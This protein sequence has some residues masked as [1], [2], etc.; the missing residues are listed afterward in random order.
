MSAC[1]CTLAGT[2]ACMACPNRQTLDPS[3]DFKFVRTTLNPSPD[4]KF[5]RTT[6]VEKEDKDAE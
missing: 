4:F 5:V 1:Y 2:L 6:L 3:P